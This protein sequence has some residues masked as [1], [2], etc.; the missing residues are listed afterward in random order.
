MPPKH[1]NEIVLVPAPSQVLMSVIFVH[2][3]ILHW[4]AEEEK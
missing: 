2:N 4:N 1:W 3:E